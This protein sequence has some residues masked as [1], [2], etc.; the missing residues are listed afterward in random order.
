MPNSSHTLH[1]RN[2]AVKVDFVATVG[3]V[4]I[5]VTKQWQEISLCHCLLKTMYIEGNGHSY[6]VGSAKAEETRPI[7]TVDAHPNTSI[8]REHFLERENSFEFDDFSDS[9][10]DCSM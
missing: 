1:N 6:F 5:D 3:C 8:P 10:D 9:E 7:T 4:G 2:H